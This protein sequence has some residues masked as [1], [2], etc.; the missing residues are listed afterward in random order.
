[1]CV[2]TRAGTSDHPFQN[3]AQVG[4][5]VHRIV[6]LRRECTTANNCS[7]IHGVVHGGCK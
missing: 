4:I 6:M 7:L 1:M 2:T 3:H 5:R